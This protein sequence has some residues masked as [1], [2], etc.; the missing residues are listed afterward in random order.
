[1]LAVATGAKEPSGLLVWSNYSDG[2]WDLYLKDD[3]GSVKRLTTTPADERF[4]RFSPDGK[5]IYYTVTEKKKNS[6][7]RINLET[8]DMDRWSIKGGEHPSFINE[9]ELVYSIYKQKERRSVIEKLNL[10][11]GVRTNHPVNRHPRFSSVSLSQ[12]VAALNGKVIMVLVN[13]WGWRIERAPGINGGAD[14]VGTGCRPASSP[15]GRSVVYVS[16]SGRGGAAI[17]A[18]D[19]IT[20][21]NRTVVDMP[22]KQTKEYDP[23]FSNDGKWLVFSA[24][25]NKGRMFDNR[26]NYRI[27]RCKWDDCR[28]PAVL[29]DLPGA[30]GF[31]D[32]YFKR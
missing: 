27:Y 19:V 10:K 23:N 4:S 17:V 16:D 21:K 3:T 8:Y 24:G 31:P 18:Y 7:R 6:I 25:L 13:R 11:T 30:D 32:L 15:D 29:A 22:G 26:A 1:M 20:G 2:N 5:W 9:N 12:P 14:L 28:K